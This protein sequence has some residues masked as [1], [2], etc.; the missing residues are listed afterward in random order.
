[1]SPSYPLTIGLGRFNPLVEKNAAIFHDINELRTEFFYASKC[2][3]AYVYVTDKL[4]SYI[5]V[6]TFLA[7]SD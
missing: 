6:S 2:V 3:C 1:M 4:L 5:S 7:E